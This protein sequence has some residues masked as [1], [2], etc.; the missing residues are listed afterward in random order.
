MLHHQF[1]ACLSAGVFAAAA[2]PCG[3]EPCHSA[4]TRR[5]KKASHAPASRQF[6]PPQG[7]SLSFRRPIG[8]K[9]SAS[10]EVT[11]VFV[12]LAGIEPCKGT[13]A[14]LG[15]RL[16]KLKGSHAPDL[17]NQERF[18]H[19]STTNAL[20]ITTRPAVSK[21]MNRRMLPDSTSCP[22][23]ILARIKLSPTSPIVC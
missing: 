16:V 3:G 2:K 1:N 7:F 20:A 21:A 19:L 4:G 17:G 11:T 18:E 22:A 12:Y 9:K 5:L 14:S 10:T 23:G 13:T 15:C 6:S 8:Q